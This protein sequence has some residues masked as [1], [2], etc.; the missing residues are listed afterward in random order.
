MLFPLGLLA[1]DIKGTV[2]DKESG[3][4]VANATVSTTRLL[5]STYSDGVFSLKGIYP[6]DTLTVKCIGYKP[7]KMGIGLY[8]AKT[9]TIYLQPTNILLQSVAIK[10]K[11]NPKSD[12]IRLRKQFAAVF[13]YKAPTFYDM[14]AKVDPYLYVPYNYIQSTNG[15]STLVTVDVL[16]VISLLDKNKDHTSKLQKTLLNDEETAYV[17]R[18]FS[19]QKITNLTNLKGDSLLDF[20]DDYRPSE[21]QVKKMSDYDMVI[22]IKNSYAQFLKNYDV[23]ER[24]PFSK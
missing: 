8:T 17:D 14:F 4:P 23:S 18:M 19:K 1:Q 2:V 24:S 7:Y 11:H 9:I 6:G 21:K 13:E 5:T 16:S 3:K 15:L 10:A 22:Y 20:M 12:S